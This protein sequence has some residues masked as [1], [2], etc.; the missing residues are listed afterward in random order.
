M[1]LKKRPSYIYILAIL[2]M[3][4]WGM[5]FV[6]T[7]MVLQYYQPVS[8]IFLRLFISSIILFTIIKLLNR[9]EKIRGKDLL[10]LMFSAFFE[11]FCYFLG[12]NYGIMQVTPSISAVIIATIPLFTPMVAYY[13]LKEKISFLNIAGIW[14]SFM[15]IIIILVNKDFSLNASPK[16]ILFLFGAVVSALVSTMLLKK[17]SHKYSSLTIIT[18]QNIAGTLYFLPL[19]FIFD[20]SQ[21][22]SIT[23]TPQVVTC[24]F[25]LAILASSLAF[26]M[27]V[28]AIRELGASKAN[29]FTNIIPIVAAIYS[30]F[31]LNEP[32]TIYKIAGMLIVVTGVY[33]SQMRRKRKI[34][35]SETIMYT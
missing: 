20:F 33:L 7:K 30:Y 13:T 1:H 32:F 27:Y 23:P 15:G 10:M 4:I 12:E 34:D 29:T 18:Y 24:L 5:S 19:F 17:L 2:P 3:I 28:N 22:I 35:S 11:P 8:I 14:L 31:A 25:L 6:W 26:I 16:G 9:S 21:F